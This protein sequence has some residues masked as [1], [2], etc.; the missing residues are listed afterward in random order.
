[1]KTP[2][3]IINRLR[4]QWQSSQKREVRLL[5]GQSGWPVVEPIGKPKPKTLVDDLDAVI[6]H[7]RQWQNVLTG[8]V[9]WQDVTYRATAEPVRVPVAWQLD[10]PSDWIEAC[11]D[12]PIRDEFKLLSTLVENVDAVFHS[13]FIRSRSLWLQKPIAEVIQ[14]CQLA[15]ELTP[16]C[17]NERPLRSLSVAGI[18]TKFFER[19][20]RLIT[21][22]LDE[23]Y[24]G[25]V[26]QMGLET[27]LD[28]IP[29]GDHWLLLIDL[30]G[31]LLPFRK[32]RIPTAELARVEL[33]GSHLLIIEN[34]SCQYQLPD[35]LSGTLA[36]LGAGFDLDWTANVHLKTKQIAY[37]GDIDSWGLSCLAKARQNLVD[38]Q[39]LLMTKDIFMQHHGAAVVEPVVAGTDI[40]ECLTASEAE[41]YLH[42]LASEYGRL[43]QEFLSADLVLAVI[44][45]WKSGQQVG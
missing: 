32:Q 44:T 21:R 25:E 18:D 33:P 5:Q 9:I 12:K 2:A 14:A 23:R 36:I 39:S 41:L 43:E 6:E 16:G 1:M 3:D 17:A 19:N 29:E 28:A 31:E 45:S 7:N 35:S 11:Q 20:A 26:S 40:P 15:S 10:K 8:S 13:L 42:L 37:W 24:D 38:L 34:E 22:L 27:F 4:R 30:D